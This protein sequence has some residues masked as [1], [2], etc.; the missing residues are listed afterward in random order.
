MLLNHLLGLAGFAALVIA[1]ALPLNVSTVGFDHA[2]Q[3]AGRVYD[4]DNLASDTWWDRYR[5][6]GSHYQCL[7][8][9]DDEAAGRLVEDTRIPP[10]AQSVW[11]GSMSGS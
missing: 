4:P 8:E 2:V 5:D 1:R 6:K 10:S 7:F 3:T 11:K 9:A